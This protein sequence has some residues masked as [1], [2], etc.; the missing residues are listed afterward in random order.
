MFSD[1]RCTTTTITLETSKPIEITDITEEVRE[2]LA[3][4]GI[5]NGTLTLISRHSTAY[6]N[7]NEKEERLLEDMETFLKRFV[8]RDGNY[9]HNIAPIDGRDNAHAHL[10]GLFM[11]ASETIPFSDGKLLLGTWQSVFF[12]EL[13][14]PRPHREVLLQIMGL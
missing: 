10:I 5:A 7:I 14:G 4:S 1:M 3:A 2:A 9:R 6:V 11:N 12:V 8:P 13:D